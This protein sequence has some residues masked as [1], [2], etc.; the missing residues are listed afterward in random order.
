[1]A[2]A[3]V[4]PKPLLA[5]PPPNS[6]FRVRLGNLDLSVPEAIFSPASYSAS[7]SDGQL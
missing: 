5:A 6:G 1:M 4:G 7:L 2:W 3:V